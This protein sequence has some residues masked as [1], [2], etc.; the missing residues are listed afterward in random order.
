MKDLASVERPKDLSAYSA[1]E[2]RAIL[3]HRYFLGIERGREPSIEE[4]IASWEDRFAR[5]W[6]RKK[7]KLDL[8]AQLREI[9]R[10]KYL[11]SEKAGRDVGWEGAAKDWIQTHGSAW[12]EWWEGQPGSGPKLES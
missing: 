1:S 5:Q 11:L 4:T 12:R 6:R 7:F 8:D 3:V 10:H 2:Q 9:D